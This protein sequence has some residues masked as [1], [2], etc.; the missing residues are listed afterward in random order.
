MTTTP[1]IARVDDPLARD[2]E[3][4]SKTEKL[5]KSAVIRRLLTKAVKEEKVDLAL[6]RYRKDEISMAKAAEIAGIPLADMLR[7]AAENKIP[8]HYT[9]GDLLRDFKA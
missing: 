5:D 9:R 1:I 7:I 3:F 2:I 4:F 6:K 8:I